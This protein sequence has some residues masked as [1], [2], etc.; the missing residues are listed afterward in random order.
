MLSGSDLGVCIAG[1]RF[2]L[3]LKMFR[4]EGEWSTS[5]IES[6][7][8]DLR[9]RRSRAVLI[10][11]PHEIHPKRKVRLKKP[12]LVVEWSFEGGKGSVNKYYRSVEKLKKIPAAF[13]TMLPKSGRFFLPVTAPAHRVRK[14]PSHERR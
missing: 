14:F 3:C 1:F 13:V 8:S 10:C 2:H 11:L 4:I 7:L 5:G 12:I 6:G 9:F